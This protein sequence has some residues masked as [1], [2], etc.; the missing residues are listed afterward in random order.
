M[1]TVIFVHL[2]SKCQIIG[3]AGFLVSKEAVSEAKSSP[4]GVVT[5]Y[6]IETLYPL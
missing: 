2:E 5:L 6:V 4:L 3:G 1:G